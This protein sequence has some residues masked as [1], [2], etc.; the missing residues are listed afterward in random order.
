SLY[1]VSIR[2]QSKEIE[3]KSK[4]NAILPSDEA[5]SANHQRVKRAPGDFFPPAPA[6]KAQR[7]SLE[8][9]GRTSNNAGIQ[10]SS[11]GCRGTDHHVGQPPLFR[12]PDDN[13]TSSSSHRPLR[14]RSQIALPAF[15]V[16][17]SDNYQRVRSYVPTH[18]RARCRVAPLLR[19]QRRF[20]SRRVS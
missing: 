16:R 2:N 9:G 3:I 10:V 15:F 17:A 4:E 19:T 7:F 18:R 12:G 20:L 13:C 5:P 6:C 8:N 11:R 14:G 1:F